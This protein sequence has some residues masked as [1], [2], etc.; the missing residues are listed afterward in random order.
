MKL[1]LHTIVLRLPKID[2]HSAVHHA[3]T[4]AHLSYLGAAALHGGVYGIAA[5]ALIVIIIIGMFLH[6][7]LS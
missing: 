6:V 1:E 3:H 5:G 4:A 2:K 7:E